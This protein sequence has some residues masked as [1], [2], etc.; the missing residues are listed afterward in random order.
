M[1]LTQWAIKW[2][3]PIDALRD[4]ERQMGTYDDQP[5]IMPAAGMSE[6]AVQNRVRLEA[7]CKG[8]RL[9]RNNVGACTDENGNHI[10]YGLAN[11]SS[12]I[13]KK[14]K[15]SDLIGIRPVLIGPEHIGQRIG[16][17]VAREVKHGAWVYTGTEHEAAQKKFLD[18]VAAQGGDAAFCNRE[19]LL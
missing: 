4:L 14:V 8:L 2:G 10:R 18:I 13:N 1:N 19:G 15:S 9:W 12:A 5:N 11:D 3:V 6:A 7:T 16:Q 17:F